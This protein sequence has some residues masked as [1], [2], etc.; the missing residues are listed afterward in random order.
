M[1]RE[2]K[3]NNIGLSFGC[4]LKKMPFFFCGV[5]RIFVVSY[6]ISLVVVIRGQNDVLFK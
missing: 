1:G 2:E 3:N 6:D 5:I 4:D